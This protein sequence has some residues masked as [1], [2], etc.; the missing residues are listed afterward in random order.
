VD[1]GWGIGLG[2]VYEVDCICT[3]YERGGG[4]LRAVSDL[5][6]LNCWW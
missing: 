3:S 1:W 6:L 5:F 2:W 4:G